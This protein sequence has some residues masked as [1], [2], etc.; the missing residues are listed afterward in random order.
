MTTNHGYVTVEN[1]QMY[2][3]E[4]G[5]GTPIVFLHAGVA[6]S[7]MW[8]PQV[9]ALS[10]GFR[11]I[12]CDLRGYGKTKIPALP[13]AYHEDVAALFRDLG[14]TSAWVVGASFGGKVAIDFTLTYPD[15]V[16]GLLLVAAAVGGSRPT[17]Q[18]LTA[19]EEEETFLEGRDIEGA[20][21]SVVRWWVDGPHRSAEEVEPAVRNLVYTMQREVFEQPTDLQPETRE[22]E[23]PAL[24]RL[25]DIHVPTLIVAGEKD[26]DQFVQ[27]SEVLAEKIPNARR[28]VIPNTAHLPSMEKPEEI[29]RLIT[30]FIE[31]S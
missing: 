21:W 15:F 3:D 24:E 13:F 27:I 14:L 12:R 16:K 7:R 1:G 2:Y 5:T 30:D 4:Q 31:A 19:W 18:T 28:V 9:D 6:D 11:V 20:T 26:L 29:N 22:L 25:G 17:A 23:P 8:Q 10:T